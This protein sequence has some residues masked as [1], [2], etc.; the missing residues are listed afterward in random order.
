M[1]LEVFLVGKS[2]KHQK[3]VGDL[4]DSVEPWTR[5]VAEWVEEEIVHQHSHE[6]G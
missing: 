6:I 4:S 5:E 3:S 1:K 2:T